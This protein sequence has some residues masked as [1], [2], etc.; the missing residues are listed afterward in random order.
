MNEK[1]TPI[2]NLSCIYRVHG[3]ITLPIG[4]SIFF[5]IA[6]L[7]FERFEDE[8]FQY[9]IEPYYDVIDGLGNEAD[10]PGIN[11]ELRQKNYYRVN[12]IP[13]FIS[14]RT[15]PSSRVEARKLLKEKNLNFYSPI[16]WLMDSKYTYTGDDLLFKSQ[17]YFD[18]LK[19]LIDSKNIYRHIIYVLQNLGLRNEFYIGNVLVT[20]TNRTFV[21]KM[22][23]HQYKIVEK[24][25]YDKLK[26]N[27]GRHKK[28]VP[29]IL[30]KEVVSLYEN[31]IISL[32]EAMT[33]LEIKS[34]AT[35]YRRLKE[36]RESLLNKQEAQ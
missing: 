1:N 33:R 25:Y 10:I 24:S 2:K 15:F 7:T 26:R 29:S 9:V 23:L 35:F 4:I 21:T 30:M 19:K 12:L 18:N 20:D 5:K 22:Y 14:D 27:K 16:L 32:E 36:Y 8:S 17:D 11:L 6:K 31:K 34:E 28:E 13:V 3:Y